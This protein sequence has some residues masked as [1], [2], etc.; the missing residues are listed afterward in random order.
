MLQRKGVRGDLRR[1]SVELLAAVGLL[2][3]DKVARQ[4]PHELSG[5]MCQRVMIAMGIACEPQI[6]VADEPTTAL[7]VTVQADIL[8]LIGDLRSRTGMGVLLISHDLGVVA[9]RCGSISVMR[10][11]KII[12]AG[13]TRTVM[14]S[15]C[16][17]FTAELVRDVMRS[18]QTADLPARPS[19]GGPAEA[20]AREA[21]G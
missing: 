6:L 15:P 20:S 11:G 1:R 7:D 14:N 13:A 10:H 16:H 12:E 3:P 17:P 8:D 4:Y 18:A 21:Q 19:P 2:Q 9:E 5:G